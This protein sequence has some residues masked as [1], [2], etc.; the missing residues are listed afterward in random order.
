MSK[1][2]ICSL[3][4]GLLVAVTMT[5]PNL[6][7]SQSRALLTEKIDETKLVTLAGSTRREA[8]AQNDR[9][10][11]DGKF[12]LH[13]MQLMLRRPPETEQALDKFIEELNDRKSPNFHK[14]LNA[15]EFG[16]RF[17]LAEGDIGTLKDW[18]KSHGFSVDVIYNNG[19]LIDFTG[20]ADQ[21]K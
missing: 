21:V 4:A 3:L 14:W 5:A 18:L 9:G 7:A 10:A 15:H 20:T 1:H 11:V 12:L 13:H 16:E 19:V 6:Q 8:N 17:G 2:S